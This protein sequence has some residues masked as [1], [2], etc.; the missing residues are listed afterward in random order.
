MPRFIVTLCS[1]ACLF[2]AGIVPARAQMLPLLP[3][4]LVTTPGRERH[5]AAQDLP[6]QVGQGRPPRHRGDE[7][8]GVRELRPHRQHRP[9]LHPRTARPALRGRSPH[10]ARARRRR[11]REESLAAALRLAALERRASRRACRRKSAP[12]TR[13]S[14][15][16]RRS[17][18]SAPTGRRY[19]CATT[20]TPSPG[21]VHAAQRLIARACVASVAGHEKARRQGPGFFRCVK[22]LCLL[23][24]DDTGTRCRRRLDRRL[25]PSVVGISIMIRPGSFSPFRRDRRC[26]RGSDRCDTQCTQ[27]CT[28]PS[29]RDRRPVQK[30][31]RRCERSPKR[32]SPPRGPAA[33]DAAKTPA[34]NG[35][36]QQ[37]ALREH[38]FCI[39][40]SAE[41]AHRSHRFAWAF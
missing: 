41:A 15:S 21:K 11:R 5:H 7:A 37:A 19:T 6:H 24:D 13:P 10:L 29:L 12:G 3:N 18:R 23:V 33:A 9:G 34:N 36:P 35:Y 30:L 32:R 26:V 1:L 16:R 2:T 25:K 4:H 20:S 17:T 27:P 28:Q 22:S 39:K 31:G 38:K 40:F 14:R 8:A